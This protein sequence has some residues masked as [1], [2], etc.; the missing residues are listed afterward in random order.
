MWDDKK[1]SISLHPFQLPFL[2]ITISPIYFMQ[3]AKKHLGI[4]I[5]KLSKITICLHEI[6][7]DKEQFEHFAYE[8]FLF[9]LDAKMFKVKFVMCCCCAWCIFM[10]FDVLGR[11]G[12]VELSSWNSQSGN[13]RMSSGGSCPLTIGYENIVLSHFS[14]EPNWPK[15]TLIPTS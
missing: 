9:G 7:L 1:V 3:I 4:T 6:Q 2:F 12:K 14:L 13:R 11:N 10:V 15:V 8:T 5:L